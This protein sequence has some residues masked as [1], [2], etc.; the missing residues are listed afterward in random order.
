MIASFL[1]DLFS[2]GFWWNYLSGFLFALCLGGALGVF[3]AII[4]AV[5]YLLRKR[6]TEGEFV[7]AQSDIANLNV[8]KFRI[9]LLCCNPKATA[10]FFF[11]AIGQCL[12]YSLLVWLT[13]L[14]VGFNGFW[15]GFAFP[16]SLALLVSLISA[17]KVMIH[18]VAKRQGIAR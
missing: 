15:I 14:K 9:W 10:T 11:V 3:L 5:P 8:D 1:S 12:V 13:S 17:P 18:D 6:P 2:L 7:Q 4:K 16:G